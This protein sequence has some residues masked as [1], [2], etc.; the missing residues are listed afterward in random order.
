[1]FQEWIAKGLS[2]AGKDQ[3]GL[4]AA[5]GVDRS[6]VS[7]IINGKRELKAKE[8]ERAA[9]YLDEA[10]PDRMMAVQYTI[11]AGQHV[12]ATGDDAAVEY[13]P[14]SGMWGKEAELAVVKGDSMFPVFAD[15][16]KLIF[17]PAR[18]PLP[19]DNRL[20]RVVRLADDRLLVKIMRKTS[21]PSVWT[22]ESLNYPP[23]EDVVVV[24]V[25]EIIR[26]EPAN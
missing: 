4:A 11:G 16:T 7:K 6:A 17:G 5:L 14:I 3:Y 8:I 25:A 10:P 21:D 22:L 15:G 26:I 2:K 9:N 24:A 1:M 19:R 12:N 20:M 18:P 23:I 13:V